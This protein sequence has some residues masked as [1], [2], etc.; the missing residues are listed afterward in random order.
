M[1]K[2]LAK[3]STV[4][5]AYG[6]P[7][8]FLLALLDSGGI[9][10]PAAIDL[11]LLDIA[12]HS[13]GNPGRA[14]TA[15]MLAVVGSLV[16]NLALFQAARQGRRLLRQAEPA[17]GERR[18]FENWF[19]HYGL[20]TVF[21]P[22]VVPFV[23]IPLKVF[24]LS[25]GAFHTPLARFFVVIVLARVIRFF[26]MVWLALE[27]GSGA[28]EFLMHHGW[29]LAG[30]ALVAAGIFYFVRSRHAPQGKPAHD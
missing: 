9:P 11:L 14:W 13:T 16:G 23:P 22:A 29:L 21:V 26:G 4:L 7:G 19:R 5:I 6:P 2:F 27:L 1:H 10:L 28:Q 17:P 30:G 12:V 20:L 18:R 24:V 8:I 3:L 25:A 15:A